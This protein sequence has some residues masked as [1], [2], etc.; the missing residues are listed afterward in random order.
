MTLNAQT[1]LEHIRRDGDRVSEVAE[2][3]LEKPVPSCPGNT[4]ESLLMHTASLYMFWS[5]A[6]EQNRRP[7]VDWTSMN[8]DL[9]AANRDGHAR[10]VELLASKDP[11]EPTWT[12]G[13]DSR[14]RFWYRRAAQE[15]SIHRWDFENA[16]GG[17]LPIDPT[18]AADGVQEFLDEFSPKPSVP[19]F[20]GAAQ[21]FDGDGERLRFEAIDVPAAWTLTARPEHFE[22]TRDGNADVTAKGPASDLDLF[23][24]GRVPPEALDVTGDSSLLRR[25]HQ[26]VKI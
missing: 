7:D 8:S 11:D 23:V 2:N 15:L 10:F 22:I 6:I 9:V 19:Q 21:M 26:R 14:M 1:Y 24:W 20:K 13:S 17:A 4:V 18:L 12:W 16:L 5:A 25:W 3:N